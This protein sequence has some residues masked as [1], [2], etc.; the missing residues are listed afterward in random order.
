MSVDPVDIEASISK[1]GQQPSGGP[2]VTV[3][4][5]KG[6]VDPDWC[7][8][9]GDFGVLTALKQALVELNLHPIR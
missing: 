8:G 5:F 4:D 3:K 7:P 9:C 6:K 1:A 2:R